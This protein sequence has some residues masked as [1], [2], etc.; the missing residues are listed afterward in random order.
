MNLLE[1]PKKENR[2]S[3]PLALDLNDM[4]KLEEVHYKI[5]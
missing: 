5:C 4:S 3:D 2:N 1:P